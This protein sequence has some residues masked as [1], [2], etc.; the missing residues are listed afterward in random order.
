MKFLLQ[1]N[2]IIVQVRKF[3]IMLKVFLNHFICDIPST[4]NSITNSPEMSTPISFTKIRILFLKTPGRS[5]FQ[6]LN[7]ITNTLRR[8]IFYMDVNMIF[9]DNS[10]KNLNIFSITYLLNQIPT[11]NLNISFENLKT[12]FCDPNYMCSQNRHCMT[13]SSLFLHQTKLIKCVATE[14]LALKVHSF[15]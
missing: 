15:N 12:I 8:A 6:S 4:P 3:S 5:S 10:F 1:N 7:K 13:H 2:I 14:S 9:T 11:P